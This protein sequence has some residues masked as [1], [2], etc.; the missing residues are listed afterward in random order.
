MSRKRKRSRKFVISLQ[1]E[2]IMGNMAEYAVQAICERPIMIMIIQLGKRLAFRIGI[3]E[4]DGRSVLKITDTQNPWI[5]SSEMEIIP[6]SM[7]SSHCDLL[8]F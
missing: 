2:E 4:L 7:N 5:V 1:I 6:T 3:Y 8:K